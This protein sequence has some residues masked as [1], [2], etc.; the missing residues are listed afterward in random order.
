M[1][2]KSYISIMLVIVLERAKT[3]LK[4]YRIDV[5]QL[6]YHII[7]LIL[8]IFA[9]FPIYDTIRHMTQCVI[10]RH[11]TQCVIIRH[12][13]QCVTIRHMTQCVTIRHMTQCVTI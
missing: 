6:F 12:M 9:I 11:M 2:F 4:A 10:I 5:K 3:A 13:T 1:L 8:F 7:V